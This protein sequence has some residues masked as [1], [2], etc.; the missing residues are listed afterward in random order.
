L[1]FQELFEMQDSLANLFFYGIC[2]EIIKKI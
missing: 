1:Y 2:I